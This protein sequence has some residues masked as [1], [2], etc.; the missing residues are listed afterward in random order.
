MAQQGPAT[1]SLPKG[2]LHESHRPEILYLTQGSSLLP[3]QGKRQTHEGEQANWAGFAGRAPSP[4]QALLMGRTPAASG[5]RWAPRSPA[6][7]FPCF[8]PLFEW[9]PSLCGSLVNSSSSRST[10]VFLRNP[11]WHCWNSCRTLRV[12]WIGQQCPGK[13]AVATEGGHLAGGLA[14]AIPIQ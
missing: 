14:P 5:P 9:H 13:P 8:V 6:L 10:L 11:A 7:Q 3:F 1:R 2:E 12:I 4:R